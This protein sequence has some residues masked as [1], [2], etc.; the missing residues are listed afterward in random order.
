MA[1]IIDADSMKARIKIYSI[2]TAVCSVMRGEGG[3]EG[4]GW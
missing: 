4:R 3:N 2:H 1:K